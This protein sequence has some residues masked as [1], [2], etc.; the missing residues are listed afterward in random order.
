MGV[1]PWFGH[2][3]TEQVVEGCTPFLSY[4]SW[5]EYCEH[6][7]S[8]VGDSVL[9]D[10]DASQQ[11][12]R[13]DFLVL[14]SI[15]DVEIVDLT[16]DTLRRLD[17]SRRRIYSRVLPVETELTGHEEV[18]QAFCRQPRDWVLHPDWFFMLGKRSLPWLREVSDLV[19][20]TVNLT[21]ETAW[22]WAERVDFVLKPANEVAGRGV[23]LHPT[24][25][26][27]EAALR[28]GTP[29]VLQERVQ[30]A[31]WV[32]PP[33]GPRLF[34]ELRMLCLEDRPVGFSCRLTRDPMCSVVN[35]KMPPWCGTTVGLVPKK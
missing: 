31:P 1:V 19:P 30:L 8:V 23:V 6:L 2:L 13:T 16:W 12:S 25:A 32:Q 22:E 34:C 20:E 10:I 28:S 18:F 14:Q 33:D 4:R 35:G 21:A 9:V 7:I 5:R 26:D 29:H 11:R 15:A 3:L 27:V 24:P 17:S